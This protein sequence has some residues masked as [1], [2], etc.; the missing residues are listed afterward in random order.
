MRLVC[1]GCGAAYTIR[2]EALG[3]A[4]RSVRCAACATVWH[5]A[6][7][8]PPAAESFAPVETAPARASVEAE[9]LPPEARPEAA[10]PPPRGARFESV[11][12]AA[13]RRERRPRRPAG[14]ASRP[15]NWSA[16]C[17]GATAILVLAGLFWREDVVRAAPQLAGLY[18]RL[19]MTVNVRGLEIRDLAASVEYDAGQ[20]V[21]TIRGRIVNIG[22]EVL[23]IP[24]LRYAVR[25]PDGRELLGWAGPAPRAAIGP[26]ESVPF[27][28]RL[29]APAPGGNDIEVRFLAQHEARP[30]TAR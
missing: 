8:A 17:L 3:E 7:E 10:A 12:R 24:R 16:V 5:A 4:G 21:T 30:G 25:G 18:A 14:G 28:G 13:S 11:E 2:P 27:Q 23:A 22:G 29:T 15:T 9:V 26:R 19:G 20:P 1:P 6:P